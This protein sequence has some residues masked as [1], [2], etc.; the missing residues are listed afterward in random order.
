[1]SQ[2]K[3]YEYVA[4]IAKCGGVSQ[5]ADLLG[6]SQPTL[7][8]QLKK[9]E[10]SVGASLFDR[11]SMPLRLTEA[12]KLFLEMGQ[13][14]L[15]LERQFQKRLMEIKDSESSVIRIG[16]SP[17]RAPY[18]LPSLLSAYRSKKPNGK[19]I[20]E[21]RT[22]AELSNHLSRGE[23]DLI[24]SMLDEGTEGFSHIP[25]FHEHMLL[26]VAS[27]VSCSTTDE[28]IK[29]LPLITVGEGQAMW[30]TANR[31]IREI[32]ANAAAIE[33]QSIESGLSLVEKGL[34]AMIVPS[35]IADFG[36]E[37]REGIRFLSLPLSEGQTY[38]RTICLFY[39]KEQYLTQAEKTFISC[40]DEIKSIPPLN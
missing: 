2:A 32:G 22:S 3:Q 5:A 37:R 36:A 12:G 39:R 1:M 9:I 13:K 28:A 38:R 35:Y 15:D 34:G 10:E 23:L 25:L 6:L 40:L 16:I 33:C 29:S 11:S 4:A 27:S 19:V 26:A 24:I 7:S 17:S 30:K 18:M 21:E 31:I 14:M 8:K 20:I